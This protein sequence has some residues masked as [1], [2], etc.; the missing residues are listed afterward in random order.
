[1]AVGRA[2]QRTIEDWVERR[3]P[4]SAAA[5]AAAQAKAATSHADQPS[6]DPSQ[7]A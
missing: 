3:R 2:R 7:P 4:G 1:M 5:D 6:T